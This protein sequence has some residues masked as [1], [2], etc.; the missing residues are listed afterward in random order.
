MGVVGPAVEAGGETPGLAV[1]QFDVG[2]AGAF[3]LVY[4]LVTMTLCYAFYTVL[5]RAGRDA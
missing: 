2:R 5:T 1:D 3:S 4:F